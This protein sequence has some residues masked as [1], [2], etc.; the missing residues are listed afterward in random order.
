MPPRPKP[1]A[2]RLHAAVAQAVY[3]GDH[4]AARQAMQEILDEVQSVF[5]T[6]AQA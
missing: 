6:T 3:G 1:A 4:V 5:D 2:L